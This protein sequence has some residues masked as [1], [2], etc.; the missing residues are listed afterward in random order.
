MDLWKTFVSSISGDER[1]RGSKPEARTLSPADF[2]G[3]RRM[4]EGYLWGESLIM[5][6]PCTIRDISPL[7]ARIV[8][9]HDDIKPQFLARPLKLF[10]SSD[11]KEADC[12]VASR[13]GNILSLRL[14]SAFHAPT[15]TYP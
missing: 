6:R 14:T 5:P 12:V 15:R 2:R 11:R 13:D 10:S 8:L 7:T 3:P 1:P 9:W 4:K